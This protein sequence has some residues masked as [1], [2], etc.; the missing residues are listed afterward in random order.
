MFAGVVM[1]SIPL[2]VVYLLLQKKFI[3]G[4]TAG[5]VKG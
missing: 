2:A 4:M 1:A 3:A 5:S